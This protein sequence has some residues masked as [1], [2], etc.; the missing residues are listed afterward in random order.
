VTSRSQRPPPRP[1]EPAWKRT[2]APHRG[3]RTRFSE[4]V[5]EQVIALYVEDWKSLNEVVAAGAD[6]QDWP[7]S[8]TGVC[9]VL[10][11]NN[12]RLRKRSWGMRNRHLPQERVAL[13]VRLYEQGYTVGRIAEMFGRN[14]GTISEHLTKAGV[15]RRPKSPYAHLIPQIRELRSNGLSWA[16]IARELGYRTPDT[17]RRLLHGRRR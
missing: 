11:A 1:P 4:E 9:G 14:S 3:H 15:Q 13:M 5:Q 2:R 8:R 7:R 10:W 16:A 6:Q 17:G 12:V